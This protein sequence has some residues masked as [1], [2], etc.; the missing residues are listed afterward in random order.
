MA[1]D[2]IDKNGNKFYRESSDMWIIQYFTAG[3][4]FKKC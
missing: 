3:L 4:R 2:N 1:D